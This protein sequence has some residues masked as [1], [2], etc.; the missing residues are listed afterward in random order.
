MDEWAPGYSDQG[1]IALS[2]PARGIL[3]CLLKFIRLFSDL[4]DR[5]DSG[6]KE[7]LSEFLKRYAGSSSELS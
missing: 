1:N 4:S 7:S 2:L 6:R 5:S 3:F